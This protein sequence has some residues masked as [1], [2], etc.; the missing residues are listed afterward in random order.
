MHSKSVEQSSCKA[1][2]SHEVIKPPENFPVF[3]KGSTA[4]GTEYKV[5]DNSKIR[6][7]RIC[8]VAPGCKERCMEFFA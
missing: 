6:L 3:K 5:S 7:T 8:P 1:G 2:S 4:F